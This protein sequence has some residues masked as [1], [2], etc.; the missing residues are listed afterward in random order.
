MAIASH[1]IGLGILEL[2]NEKLVYMASNGD[3]TIFQKNKFTLI[4]GI[5]YSNTY[6]Q[7]TALIAT[8]CIRDNKSNYKHSVY[9][10]NYP[11]YNKFYD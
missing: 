1:Y 11:D 7:S 3:I 10:Y 2:F 9:S 5:Y 4:D 6:W 8:Q